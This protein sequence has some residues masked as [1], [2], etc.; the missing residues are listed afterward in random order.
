VLGEASCA[1]PG[2]SGCTVRSAEQDDSGGF[3]G[4]YGPPSQVEGGT[5]ATDGTA[6]ETDA[7]SGGAGS[8]ARRLQEDE[9][10][11]N[12]NPGITN[13]VYCIG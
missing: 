6:G 10:E 13:P 3:V 7:S 12:S 4:G 2:P 1:D 11:F 5:S 9:A 8:A